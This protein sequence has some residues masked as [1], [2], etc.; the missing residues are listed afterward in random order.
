MEVGGSAKEPSRFDRLPDAPALLGRDTERGALDELLDAARD[1]RGDAMVVYGEAGIGKT[2]LLEY[3]I[4][5]A[6]DFTVLRTVGN[7]AERELPFAA[8]Q[9]L[10]APDLADLSQLPEPQR[11]ALGVT[12]GSCPAHR[13]IACW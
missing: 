3:M 7:E 6:H 2:A 13:P 12:F 10:C 11:E 5:S 8:L 9:Q 1:G 4:A